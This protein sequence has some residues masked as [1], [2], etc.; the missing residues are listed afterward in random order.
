MAFCTTS[1]NRKASARL[2]LNKSTRVSS[3][4]LLPE[5]KQKNRFTNRQRALLVLSSRISFC[6]SLRKYCLIEMSA[7]NDV[8]IAGAE[9]SVETFP[10]GTWEGVTPHVGSMADYQRIQQVSLSVE[11]FL[12]VMAETYLLN[13]A[14]AFQPHS[15]LGRC[16]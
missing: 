10:P 9:I 12:I 5:P 7:D 14:C 2:G 8:E 3:Y 4:F 16:R 1:Q 13:T 11:Y 6:F 15:I